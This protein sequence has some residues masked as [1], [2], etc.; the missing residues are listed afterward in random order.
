M[1]T[2]MTGFGFVLL[3]VLGLCSAQVLFKHRFE[4]YGSIPLSAEIGAYLL[5]VAKDIW[6]LI[7]ACCMLI[8]SL[9]WYMGLSRL[10]LSLASPMTSL[11]YPVI[12]IASFSVL[13]EPISVEKVVGNVFIVVGILL[14]T[15]RFRLG[16]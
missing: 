11:A 13:S 9:S 5:V 6:L 2:R 4:L 16:R 10:P 15:I 12:L 14:N 8:S 1:N 7:A 3:S